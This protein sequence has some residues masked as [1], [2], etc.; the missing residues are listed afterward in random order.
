MIKYCF[1]V[2]NNLHYPYVIV[3]KNHDMS[4]EM[5]TPEEIKHA[6]K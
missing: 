5:H 6:F 3:S 4:I 1:N 2:T